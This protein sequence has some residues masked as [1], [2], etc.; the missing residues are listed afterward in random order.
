MEEELP[1]LACD[2]G[3]GTR[4]TSCRDGNDDDD[5]AN[6]IHRVY[7]FTQHA[8]DV[9][10]LPDNWGHATLNLEASLGAAFIFDYC[11]SAM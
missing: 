1:G 7:Q 5:A 9:V 6:I 10:L 8:G 11:D 2:S 3:A 4:G